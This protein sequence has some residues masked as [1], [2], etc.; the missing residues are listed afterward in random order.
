M[1]SILSEY[2]EQGYRVIALASRTLT[3][4]DYKRVTFM[5][6]EDIEK[7]L[8]FLGLIILENRLKP[9]TE[10][11]IKELKDAHIKVVMI[12]GKLKLSDRSMSG[13]QFGI[14][15]MEFGMILKSQCTFEIDM[16]V[17]NMLKL[18]IHSSHPAGD[19]IQT[20]ISVAKECG[21]IDPGETVVDVSAVG[22]GAKES[23]K[24][25]YTISGA[26]AIQKK[27]NKLNYSKTEEELG[28]SAGSY[29]F[30]VTGKSWEII[31]N[32][33]PDLIPKLIVKGAIF[34]RMSSDQK[35][36]LVLELQQLGY[37]VGKFNVHHNSF[38]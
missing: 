26:A 27:T 9:Q 14:Y 33:L 7:D 2:T 13:A 1:V 18:S 22:G 15:L 21:I 10:G 4:P 34:A 36:Q 23:A 8:E 19:N 16:F 25:F 12:T 5:K 35:Q 6:R 11:V 31:R 29:K 32:E 28:L 20:A 30:A 38:I 17:E 3:L 24:V 37:Y